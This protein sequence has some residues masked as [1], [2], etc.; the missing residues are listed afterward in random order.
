MTTYGDDASYSSLI[1]GNDFAATLSTGDVPNVNG[2][3]FDLFQAD[4]SL[5]VDPSFAAALPGGSGFGDVSAIATFDLSASVFNNLFFITVDSSDIDDSSVNDVIFSIDGTQFEYPFVIDEGAGDVSMSFS[6][7]TVKYGAVNNQYF[8]QSLKKDV[9]RHIAKSITGGYAVA[10][11]FSNESSLIADVSNQDVQ[12][13]NKLNTAIETLKQGG[14][15]TI[16]Q[17][18]NINDPDQKRFFQVAQ[19][20]FGINMN[21]TGGRQLDIYEDLSNNSVDSS[22]NPKA[23]VTVPLRFKVNDAIALR[24]QYDPKSSPVS[25][26]GNNQI[27]SRSYKILITLS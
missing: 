21:D 17:I 22:G 7:A 3:I 19:A 16:D 27:P 14:S 6:N 26:M 18:A 24:I 1:T 9:V 10:D 11:I 12:I 23:S 15:Y 13:H 25:G 4:V 20:L 5:A 2:Y 8:D